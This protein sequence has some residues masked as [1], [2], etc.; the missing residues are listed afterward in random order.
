LSKKKNT[1]SRSNY[2]RVSCV[3]GDQNGDVMH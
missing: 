2:N 1:F 3:F